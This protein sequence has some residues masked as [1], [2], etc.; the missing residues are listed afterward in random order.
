MATHPGRHCMR[1][2]PRH[3]EADGC[4]PRSWGWGRRILRA[5]PV[6]PEHGAGGG[7][8]YPVEG[9]VKILGQN[10]FSHRVL[11]HLHPT[12]EQDVALLQGQTLSGRL[13][14]LLP[15]DA[16]REPLVAAV[17]AGLRWRPRRYSRTTAASSDSGPE[18]TSR[19]RGTARSPASSGYAATTRSARSARPRPRPRRS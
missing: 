12:L 19:T 15:V 13:V 17:L 2:R 9:G 10:D 4:A 6:R 8:D 16:S 1:R 3:G 18:T 5:A 11:E 14:G 7:G